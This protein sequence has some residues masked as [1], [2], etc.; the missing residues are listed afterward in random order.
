MPVERK[1]T[2]QLLTESVKQ[3]AVKKTINK[4]HV[5]DIT[6]NCSMSKSNFYHH[7]ADKYEL[8][9]Y[10]INKAVDEKVPDKH[11]SLQEFISQVLDILE[12]EA[13]FYSNVLSNTLVD[14]PHHAFFHESLDSKIKEFIVRNC[15]TIKPDRQ[16]DLI[17]HVYLAGVTAAMCSHVINHRKSREELMNAFVI[18]IPD[19]LR[20]YIH[21]DSMA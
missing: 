21:T 5:A 19:S 3:L 1:D 18:A 10:I 12:E 2:K 6:R 17:L 14:Y 16:L 11:M 9:S 13:Q 15:M 8:I 4:I 7:F 20:P